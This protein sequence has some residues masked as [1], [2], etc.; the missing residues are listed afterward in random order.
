MK[1]K[2]PFSKFEKDL[3][4][5]IDENTDRLEAIWGDG[6]EIMSLIYIAKKLDVPSLTKDYLGKIIKI[7]SEDLE[8]R[9]K[10][11][12]EK[13]FIV[14]KSEN[15]YSITKTGVSSM[16]NEGKAK[17]CNKSINNYYLKEN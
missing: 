14:K 5:I 2:I 17:I 4:K 8:T 6:G 11:L 9:L 10:F 16:E 7:P 1:G 15:N 13:E 3:C 12:T